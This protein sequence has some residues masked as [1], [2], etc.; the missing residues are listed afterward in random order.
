[1]ADNRTLPRS[2]RYTFLPLLAIGVMAG[3]VASAIIMHLDTSQ[4]FRPF[5]IVDGAVSLAAAIVAVF[6]ANCTLVELWAGV[7]VGVVLGIAIHVG[8]VPVVDG[9][10]RN[11]W[12]FEFVFFWVIGFVPFCLGVWL[13]RRFQL[14]RTGRGVA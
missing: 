1:M 13:A 7:N 11:L 6:I 14:W 9:G 12:P 10:E 3:I 5:V 2:R 4:S 8:F